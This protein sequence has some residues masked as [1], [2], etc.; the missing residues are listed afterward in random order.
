[1]HVRD[2]TAEDLTPVMN[3]LDGAVLAVDVE[4]VRASIGRDATL[5]AISDEGQ[6][7]GAL[8]LDGCHIEAVA[9]RRR[10][11]GQG[12]G[13][14]LIT[15]AADGRASLTAEFDVAVRPF[16]ESLGFAVDSLEEPGR[17]RAVYR[18]A[19]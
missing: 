3:V 9:V 16:Y 4:T 19:E 5:V 10:R 6:V 17:C 8:V 12:I 18:P 15:T 7:L 11:R 14:A 1:M 13:T 2:A